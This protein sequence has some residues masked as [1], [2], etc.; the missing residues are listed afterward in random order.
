LPIITSKSTTPSEPATN[1]PTGS[2]SC[3]KPC[4][5]RFIDYLVLRVLQLA[6]PP[7]RMS[8]TELSETVVRSTEGMTQIFDR[9]AQADLVA[10]AA[11]P[12][13]AAWSWS[14]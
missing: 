8:P 6:G 10:R 11:D 4:G 12:R 1:G 2:P 14:A 7:Y 3:L 13:I 9:F 5:L